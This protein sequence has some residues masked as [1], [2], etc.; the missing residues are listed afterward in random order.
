MANPIKKLLGQTAIYGLSSIISR[1]LNF[2]LVPFYVDVF[3]DPKDYGVISV[4]YSFVAFL[5]VLL[6]FGMETAYF[7]FVQDESDKTKVFQT[8]FV[9]LLAVNIF[10]FIGIFFA[11]GSIA[12]WIGVGEHPEYITLLGLIVVI[13]AASAL[14]LA[15]LRQE[16]QAKKFALIQFSGIG[17]NI[18]LNLVLLTFFFDKNNP[19]EGV[20]MILIANLLSSLVKPLLC[21]ADFKNIQ[22][23]WDAELGKRMLIYAFPLV[24]AGF[25]GIVNETIDRILLVK[26]IPENQDAMHEIGVYSA[27]YKIAMLVSIVLQAYR[28]A[29]EPFFF[30][31]KNNTDRNK[32]Y[33]KLMNYFVAFVCLMFLVI[34]LN[35]HIFKYFIPN[36]NYW[37]GLYVVPI[38]LM[39]NVF[40]GIYLNQSV[41]YKLSDKTKYGAYIS[42]IGAILTIIINV[43]FIPIYGYVAAAWAT[44]IVYGTQ[45]TLSYFWGQKHFPIKY[46]RRKFTLY[47]GSTVVFYFISQFIAIEHTLLN[48]L[49]NNLFVVLFILLVLKIEGISLKNLLKRA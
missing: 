29:A 31:Q 32:T 19:E 27:C 34:S 37:E 18:I 38:L 42:V 28:Y 47:L 1:T 16:N 30:N 26:L 5:M 35:I 9:S 10:F 13:D 24:I 39:A 23:K 3:Q 7:R 43:V 17:V 14:P 8:G 45:M 44:M 22:F 4:L 25:A 20:M 48:F 2:F 12:E 41:W 15:K 33:I 40:L 6:T 46:N 21:Y 36:K 49:K 11:N